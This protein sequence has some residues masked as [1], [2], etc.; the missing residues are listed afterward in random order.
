MVHGARVQ[1]MW[2]DY[3]GWG[4]WEKKK[5]IFVNEN[6]LMVTENWFHKLSWMNNLITWFLEGQKT[7][8]AMWFG[9]QQCG[10]FGTQEIIAHVVNKLSRLLKFEF[11]R[12]ITW[13]WWLLYKRKKCHYIFISDWYLN[14][15]MCMT[16]CL[17]KPSD[18]SRP[19]CWEKENWGVFFLLLTFWNTCNLDC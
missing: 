12:F 10:T 6:M 9:M 8:A 3:V 13:Q 1:L 7:N 2:V 19:L 17:W 5:N 11:I 18:I 4:C 16:S 15:V 14:L